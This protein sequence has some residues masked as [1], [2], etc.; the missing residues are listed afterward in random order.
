MLLLLACHAGPAAPTWNQDVAPIVERHCAGC[1]GATGGGSGV[2]LTSYAAA[3]AVQGLL[4]DAVDER[5]MPPWL[6]SDDCAAYQ[7]DI[8]LSESDRATLLAWVDGGA[9]EGEPRTAPAETPVE[10]PSL[11]RVD[12]TLGMP[13]PYTPTGTDDYRCFLL[14]W[15]ET[16]TAWVTGFDVAP[17]DADMVH[18]AIAFLIHPTDADA[19]RALDAADPAEGYA[20]YGGPGGDVD[21]LVRTAWLGGWAHGSGATNL[22]DGT[23]LE[24]RPGSLVVLQMHYNTAAGAGPDQS[25]LALTIEHERQAWASLEPWTDVSW[26]LGAGMDIPPKTEGV[27]H[28][29]TYTLED[30]DH[31][32]I[33]GA[34]LHLH[35]LARSARMQVRHADGSTSCL[36]DIPRYDFDWQR[37]YALAEPVGVEA[38]D[39]L[40]LSCTWDNPTDRT[41]AWGETTSDEM[42]LGITLLTE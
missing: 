5:R 21:T 28:E 2:P 23:G 25:A 11:A 1:H 38:G 36:L 4:R 31:F 19:Y 42:C 26:I 8:S 14:D 34:A 3:A 6:A 15:P 41:V 37:E 9:P 30:D 22:P 33:H 20:C 10:P 35:T 13:E 17:G 29:F 39:T 16:E 40:E 27:T 18:H 32:R 24:V 7:D 12:R